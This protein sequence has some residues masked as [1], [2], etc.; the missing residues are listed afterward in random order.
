MEGKEAHAR[1]RR[2]RLGLHH[3]AYRNAIL[4]KTGKLRPAAVAARTCTDRASQEQEKVHPTMAFHFAL[5]DAEAL[6]ASYP[7]MRVANC[8]VCCFCEP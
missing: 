5:I 8:R 6:P 1:R 4:L 7:A 2:I 3:Q